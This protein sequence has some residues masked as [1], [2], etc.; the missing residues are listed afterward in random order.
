MDRTELLLEE[1]TNASGIPG[2]EGQVRNIMQRNLEGIASVQYDKL[3]GIVG[4]KRGQANSPRVMLSSHMDEIGFM[5]RHITQEGAI[6]FHHVGGIWDQLLPGLR[7]SIH[8]SGGD[9]LGVVGAKPPHLQFPRKEHKKAVKTKNLYVDIGST[10]A[11]ETANMGVRIGDPIIPVSKFTIMSNP[12]TYLAKA[13]DDRVACALAIQTVE[14]LVHEEHP[15]TLYAAGTVFE[16]QGLRGAITMS[17]VVDP[18]VAIILEI[19][20]CGDVPGID[21]DESTIKLGAGPSLLV[22]DTNMIPNIKLKDLVIDT[23]KSMEIP[24]QFSA[25]QGG[26]TDGAKIHVHKAGVPTIVI[27]VPTRHVHSFEGIIHRDDYDNALE[28]IVAVIKKLDAASVKELTNWY[29]ALL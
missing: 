8:T 11:R 4:V 24:L 16:E 2:F 23:A 5:V 29:T 9:V 17:H 20:F 10:S 15:N 25:W 14:R 6:R 13:F 21:E 7:V 19:D 1:L 12:K 27:G 3:G 28:L 26:C 22:F 18:D